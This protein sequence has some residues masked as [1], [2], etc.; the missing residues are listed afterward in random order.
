MTTMVNRAQAP[1]ITIPSNIKVRE[2]V[3]KHTPSGVKIYCLD[4]S[5][6]DVVRVSFVFRA[7]VKY[8]K[9]PFSASAAAGMLGEGCDGYT[10]QEIA[11]FLDF[12]GIY[13][14]QSVDR[15][16]AV[17]TIC[18]LERFFD[19]SLEI[20][21]KIITSP[22]YLE[23]ELEIYK[24][25][26]KQVISM[27]RAKIDFVARENFAKSLFGADHH[28]GRS[29]DENLY[30]NLTSD[31]L[32]EFYNTHYTRANMFVVTSGKMSSENFA[33]LLNLI[34]SLPEGVKIEREERE[35]IQTKK[36]R[37]PW[38]E[39]RQSAIRVGRM[40]FTRTHPDFVALQVLSTILG[41]YF[42]SRLIS[43]LRED[44]GYTYGI[45]SGVINLEESGYLAITTEVE[46]SVTD[47]A[48]REIFIEIARLR[49]ELVPEEELSMVK[50]VMIGEILR[51]L[52]G[53]FGIADITIE[54]VL[55]ERRNEH[56]HTQIAQIREITPEKIMDTAKKYL[57]DDDF[58]TVVVSSEDEKLQ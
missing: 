47:D 8:Q 22:S 2:E 35:F 48:V 39:A 43:N 15:D 27:E 37:L 14:D 19:K 21:S 29:Y 41:G 25:K 32:R 7:G 38:K 11:D 3:V 45:F 50:N 46:S 57:N 23:H 49:E 13:F 26:R 20:L 56:L 24:S 5:E 42:G 6:Y 18:S 30:D 58:V 51:I 53:P 40:L 44:K 1:Q 12:Y 9:I 55:S 4:F 54:N 17:I 10:S 31:H 16:Y 28:Y 36:L 33:K 52:D 34:D